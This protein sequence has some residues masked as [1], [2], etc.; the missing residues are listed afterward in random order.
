MG[1]IFF[2]YFYKPFYDEAD[3]LYF[4]QASFID[5]GWNGYPFA[6]DGLDKETERNKAVWI[7]TPSC[8]ALY[9]R[10]MDVMAHATRTEALPTLSIR[11]DIWSLV[12]RRWVQLTVFWQM[13]SPGRRPLRLWQRIGCPFPMPV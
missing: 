9:V 6:L 2:D 12:V 10:G 11:T 8:N 3:G 5:V 4:G 7:K 13:W 1:N